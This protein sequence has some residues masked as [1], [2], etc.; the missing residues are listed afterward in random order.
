MRVVSSNGVELQIVICKGV[1]VICMQM[2]VEILCLSSRIVRIEMIWYRIMVK[3][4]K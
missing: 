1:T 3:I 4:H 2:V